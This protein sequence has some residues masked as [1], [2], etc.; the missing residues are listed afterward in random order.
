MWTKFYPILTPYPPWV[1]NC[2]H[3]TQYHPFVHITK[4]ALSNHLPTSSCLHSYWMPLYW[5]IRRVFF[6]FFSS[7]WFVKILSSLKI[8]LRFQ[9][10]IKY[11]KVESS[12][13]SVSSIFKDFQTVYE[14]EIW[15][16]CTV[17]FDQ[18]I[19]NWIVDRS[20]CSRLYSM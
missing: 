20:S 10:S 7:T 13:I 9:L 12:T 8:P 18:E 5:M 15:C 2:G 17:T 19:Q 14:G 4:R 6:M 3:F 11:C 16:L 1:N